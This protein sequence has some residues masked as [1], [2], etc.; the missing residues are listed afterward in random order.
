[1][2]EL[3]SLEDLLD[4][5]KVD[6]EL[7][8]LLHRRQTLSQLDDYRRVHESLVALDVTLAEVGGRFRESDLASDRADGEL[9]LAEDKLKREERRLY[10]GG[11]NARDSENMRQEVAMLRRQISEKEDHILALIEVKEQAESELV[12]LRSQR[13]ELQAEK[14]R[15]DG[16][17]KEEWRVID[18]EI[19]L[20]EARKRDIVPLIDV[21]LLDLYDELRPI[22]QGVAVGRLSEGICGGCHLQLSSAERAEVAREWPPR[23]LHCRRILVPQ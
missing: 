7:D 11:L 4:L 3:R 18:S 22:K 6:L 17:I 5:Q 2:E 12:Q 16:E 8:R 14:D 23:C 13:A 19:A 1:M 9:G 15:L 10:A 20:R 21:E